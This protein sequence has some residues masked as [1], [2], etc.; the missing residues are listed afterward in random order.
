MAKT[1][2]AARVAPQY[3][4]REAIIRQKPHRLPY[5]RPSIHKDL[6]IIIIII[7]N[8]PTDKTILPI[9]FRFV[10]EC[11]LKGRPGRK[12]IAALSGKGDRFGGQF[13]RGM[14][15]QEAGVAFGCFVGGA[16]L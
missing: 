4:Q 11:L 1:Q 16:E 13:A 7:I 15:D 8:P 5:L 10:F 3:L 2:N 9:Q 12:P 14:M 6:P